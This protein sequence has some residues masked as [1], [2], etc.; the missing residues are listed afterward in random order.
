MEAEM[1]V[2]K[3]EVI[4]KLVNFGTAWGC[5]SSEF[6]IEV[7]EESDKDELLDEMQT[8]VIGTPGGRL[9]TNEE[10]EFVNR[11]WSSLVEEVKK[12]LREMKDRG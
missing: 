3:E 5:E 8:D 9:F 4:K 7:F 12:K 1:S 2:D 11:N 6:G 10:V